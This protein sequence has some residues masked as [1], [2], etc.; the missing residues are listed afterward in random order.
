MSFLRLFVAGCLCALLA[1]G[2]FAVLASGSTR[3]TPLLPRAAR[4]ERAFS[5]GPTLELGRTDPSLQ[6]GL[7]QALASGNARRLA[8]RGDLA[9][10]VVDLSSS[11]VR[12]AA[13]NGD[14]MMYAAS[15]PK[16]AILLGAFEALEQ[17]RL[18]DTPRLRQQLVDMIRISDNVAASNVLRE[19]GFQGVADALTE[20]SVR[21]YD[22][23]LGGGLWVGKAYGR[24]EYWQGDPVANLS[25][26]ATARQV[27]RFFVMLHQGRL[28]SPQ[29][30]G[31]MK[32]ILGDPGIRHKFVRGLE[33]RPGAVVYRKSGTWREYHADA[34]LSAHGEAVYVAVGL[35]HDADGEQLLQR[36]I[37]D[38]DDLVCQPEA[39][40]T[41]C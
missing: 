17:G 22:P 16:I 26:G 11:R 33:A 20:G 13:I 6:R 1:V 27:A 10:A 28:V 30:S 37:V 34:A 15:L 36:L 7:E 38:I 3:P 4:L 39:V 2:S 32:A 31:Q 24:D 41:A 25:H 14:R 12:Y 9:L 19:V 29:A 8:A 40:P 21:L 23:L 5:G 35:V 18:P